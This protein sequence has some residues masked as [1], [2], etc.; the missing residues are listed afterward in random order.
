MAK[1]QSETFP[2]FPRELVGFLKELRD[3]NDKT[4][5]EA[6]R[7]DYEALLVAPAQA[8]VAAMAGIVAAFEPPLGADPRTNRSLRRIHRDTRFSADKRPFHDQLHVIFWAGERPNHGAGVHFVIGPDSLGFGAGQWG[9]EGETLARYRAAIADEAS[10][11]ALA[12][13]IATAETDGGTRLDPPALA[14]P[15]RGF[16]ASAPHGELLRHKCVIVRSD[17][18]HPD[19]LF[20]DRLVE[21]ITPR[22]AAMMPLIGWLTD[23]LG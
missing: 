18:P 4:W 11:A 2:G 5:F 22:I 8:F 21:T 23:E 14:R 16:D 7:T 19:W 12:A 3:N 10:A 6:H 13:A 17:E 15:P 1:P 9:F 20:D